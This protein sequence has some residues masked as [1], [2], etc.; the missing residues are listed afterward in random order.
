[1]SQ[2]LG[3][4]VGLDAVVGG[5]DDARGAPGGVPDVGDTVGRRTKSGMIAL[6]F[7]YS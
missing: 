6:V 5:V 3:R 1:M 2:S 7:L 4:D